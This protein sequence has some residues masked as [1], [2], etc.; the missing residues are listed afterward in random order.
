MIDHQELKSY[1]QV[2]TPLPWR[3]E[4]SKWSARYWILGKKDPDGAQRIVTEAVY[5]RFKDLELIVA[6][7][8]ALPE[9]LETIERLT[10]QRDAYSSRL[11][12]VEDE[13]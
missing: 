10:K 5:P 8:N 6:A 11:L 1:L 4:R 9:L 2:A 12:R 3:V 7:V 13:D